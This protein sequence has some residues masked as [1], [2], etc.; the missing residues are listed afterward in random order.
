[1]SN[2]ARAI[3]AKVWDLFNVLKDDEVTYHQYVT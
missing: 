2:V 1:M 3:V